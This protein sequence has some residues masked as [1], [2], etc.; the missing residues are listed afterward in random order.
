MGA[1]ETGF[2]RAG[3]INLQ[4]FARGRGPETVL[5]VHGYQASARVWRL[6][7]DALDPERFRTIALNNR[8]AGE[9]DRTPREDDYRIEAFATDLAAAVDALAL[10]D[11]TLVG[12][13]L[14][15]ATVAQFA[16]AHQ[17]LLRALVLLNP[18]PLDHRAGRVPVAATEHERAVLASAAARERAS[19]PDDF[20]RAL[21]ADMAQVPIERTAGGRASMDTVRLRERLGELRVPVL[22]AGG[23]QDQVVGVENI[24]REYLALPAET[25]SLH[26]IHGAGH[27]PNVGAPQEVAAVLTRFLTAVLNARNSPAVKRSR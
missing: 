24:L 16:L 12:H 19:A 15:G 22:V 13:S 10:R 9:S 3:A 4:Y 20:L 1:M 6:V 8:G 27:S 17:H 5:F 7:Q 23:D 14:G 11:F 26:M 25:R 18:I 2:V 21:D